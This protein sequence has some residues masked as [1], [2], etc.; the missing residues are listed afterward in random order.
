MRLLLV[1]ILLGFPV[2]EA[3]LLVQLGRHIGWWLAVWLG[4]SAMTGVALIREARL[5]MLKELTLA[6]SRGG[7]NIQALIGSGRVLFA[8]LLFIFPGVVSD[9]IALGLILLPHPRI[10]PAGYPA[11]ERI[12]EGDF[13][14]E[15]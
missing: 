15:R 4:M 8:G 7:S 10:A 14:R 12:I 2:L 6:L 9:I 13:R 5:S 1:I 3:W 11:H